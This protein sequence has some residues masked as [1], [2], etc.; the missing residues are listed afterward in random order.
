MHILLTNDDG[1]YA[2]G[3]RALYLELS[4]HARLT[5]VAPDRERSAVGH[6]ITLDR[7]LRAHRMAVFDGIPAYAVNGTPADCVK[8]AML[9]LLPEKPDLVISGINAGANVGVNINYSGTVAAARE[10]SLY[11]VP[12]IAVS[13]QGRATDHLTDTARFVHYL[14]RQVVEAGLPFGTCLN[15]NVPNLALAATAG[16]RVSKQG[17]ELFPE[18]VDKRVDPRNG[19]YYWQ[20]CDAQTFHQNPDSDGSALDHQYVTITPITCDA[21]DYR[22]LDQMQDW[23]LTLK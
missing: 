17:I 14:C 22:F 10:A 13:I 11:G 4:R 18:Y 7:P 1:I 3:L 21:T 5:V 19:T 9:D 15:V 12:A 16:V 20:G 23:K 6:G 8:L 2:D